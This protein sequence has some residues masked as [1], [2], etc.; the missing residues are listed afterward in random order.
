MKFEQAKNEIET[1]DLLAW[2][3]STFVG[4][5]VR[6]WTK[7]IYSHIGV[8][9]V[10][11]GRLFVLEAING[12]GVRLRPIQPTESFYFV[13]SGVKWSQE[14]EDFAMDAVGMDVD[15]S[16]LDAILAGINLKLKGRG[17]Q[18]AEFVA[19]I[20]RRCGLD[21]QEENRTPVE[22]LNEVSDRGDCL[23]VFVDADLVP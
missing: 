20:Y 5:I 7:S 13:K 4:M 22:V 8:A 9:W 1:G 12:D 15:Y 23:S 18:C 3:S 14:A 19:K 11:N 2:S 21:L 17:F 10:A 6:G 16:Y